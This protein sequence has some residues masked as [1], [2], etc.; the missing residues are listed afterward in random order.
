MNSVFET[1]GQLSLKKQIFK[2][3]I[4]LTEELHNQ[5]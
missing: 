4:C 2:D 3:Q 1:F 5:K